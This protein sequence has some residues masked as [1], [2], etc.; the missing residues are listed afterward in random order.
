MFEE[1]IEKRVKVVFK[2]GEQI[3]ALRGV[4]LGIEGEGEFMFVNLGLDG[5][6]MKSI[7]VNLV[8]TITDANSDEVRR[9]GRTY[10]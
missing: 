4:F 7:K 3:K 9:D 10:D 6:K 5:G 1:Y 8:E 2:D